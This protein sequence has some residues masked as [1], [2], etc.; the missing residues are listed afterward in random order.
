M[1]PNPQPAECRGTGSTYAG[2]RAI[3]ASVRRLKWCSPHSMGPVAT[4]GGEVATGEN[5]ASPRAAL[6]E[7][8]VRA[9][10]ANNT[11]GTDWVPG[12]SQKRRP[13][14]WA[15]QCQFQIARIGSKWH[16]MGVPGDEQEPPNPRNP[17]IL[18]ALP[19][20]P[21]FICGWNSPIFAGRNQHQTK[22]DR[23][24]GMSAGR[25]GA[26]VPFRRCDRQPAAPT[27]SVSR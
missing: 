9:R 23:R 19:H 11:A 12:I 13:F 16:E 15:F 17:L 21:D 8:G 14:C 24:E 10:L 1:P 5:T 6:L 18:P 7:L 2:W 3:S 25:S 26:R 22:A 4:Q 27:P 20:K